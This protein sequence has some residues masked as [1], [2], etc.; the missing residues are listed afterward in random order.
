MK[1]EEKFNCLENDELKLEVIEKYEGDEVLIPFYYYNIIRKNDNKVVG[2]ISIR[3]GNNFHSYYN[4]HIGYEIDNNV[5]GNNYALKASKLVL[6]VAKFHNMKN[7]YLTCEENNVASY[8]TIEKLGAKLIEI[9]NIPKEYF[10]YREG[11]PKYRIYQL[12]TDWLLN[13]FMINFFWRIYE[14]KCKSNNN[15]KWKSFNNV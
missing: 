7:I 3:I 12:E 15:W 10:A 5:R 8:K 6:E 4:G 9:C 1:F 2:K 11:I 13:I 14:S